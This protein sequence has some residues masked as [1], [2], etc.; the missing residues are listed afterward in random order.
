MA[1]T[2]QTMKKTTLG[3]TRHMQFS[4]KLT[5]M[6][7]GSMARVISSR[8]VKASIVMYLCHDGSKCLFCCDF[9][10]WVV[11]QCCLGLEEVKPELYATDVKF[12]CPSCHELGECMV[13]CK[14]SPYHVLDGPTTLTGVCERALKAQVC[15]KLILV[16]HLMYV[17]MEVHGSLPKLVHTTIEEY[18]MAELLAYEEVTFDFGTERKLTHWMKKAGLLGERLTAWNFGHK[19]IFITVHSITTCGD[20][21]TGKDKDGDVAMTVKDIS[22]KNL[23]VCLWPEYTI[24]FTVPEFIIT[25]AKMFAMAYSI[26]VLIQGHALLNIFCDLL[27]ISLELRMHTDVLIFHISSLVTPKSSVSMGQVLAHGMLKVQCSLSMVPI[28]TPFKQ[29]APKGPGNDLFGMQLARIQQNASLL[30][31][32]YVE[33]PHKSQSQAMAKHPKTAGQ[34]IPHSLEG[35]HAV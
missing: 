11:C 30:V 8:A 2:K 20:L 27:N 5:C 13:K 17:G 12:K 25:A 4:V 6:V 15:T 31:P 28:N 16:L 34:D 3:S 29:Y 14:L 1:R 35:F 18:H 7:P 33:G 24:L 23:M 32:S 19:I 26:Q 9:C 10:P 22:M 21:F